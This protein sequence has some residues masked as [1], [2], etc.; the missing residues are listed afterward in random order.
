MMQ[1][2]SQPGTEQDDAPTLLRHAIVRGEKDPSSDFVPRGSKQTKHCLKDSTANQ[3]Q[4]PRHILHD[5]RLWLKRPQNPQ[6]FA[7]EPVPRV[8]EKSLRR[9]NRKTLTRRSADEAI[10]FSHADSEPKPQT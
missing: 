8:L 5:E 6:V 9:V 3:R 2:T 10:E 4:E 7:K 1:R